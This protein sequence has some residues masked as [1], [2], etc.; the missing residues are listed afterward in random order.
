[1][2]A[3]GGWWDPVCYQWDVYAVSTE[4]P[5]NEV[6]E[7]FCACA[8]EMK[9]FFEQWIASEKGLLSR[10][11]SSERGYQMAVMRNQ[12]ELNAYLDGFESRLSQSVDEVEISP[13]S[14]GLPRM[15]MMP[16]KA[17]NPEWKKAVL[18]FTDKKENNREGRVEWLYEL[19]NCPTDDLRGCCFPQ[20]CFVSG[21]RTFRLHYERIPAGTTIVYADEIMRESGATEADFEK[22]ACSLEVIRVSVPRYLF[23]AMNRP[24]PFQKAW[25]ERLKRLCGKLETCVGL[26][27]MD[28]YSMG[29]SQSLLTG[30]GN[31]RLAFRTYLPDIGWGMG[32]TKHQLEKMGGLDTLQKASIFDAIEPLKNGGV[33]LQLTPDISVVPK[34]AAKALWKQ[35]SPYL[36]MEDALNS[37][38]DVPPSMRFGVDRSDLC[39]DEW[40]D[41]HFRQRCAE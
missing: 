27:K 16:A 1:M 24:F 33:Y 14:P 30:N 8:D 34:N 15:L 20:R 39:I 9:L 22:G 40:G 2:S 17:L 37:S 11:H 10:I 7:A 6:R 4:G 13:V 19:L 32:L 23:A 5:S 36:K 41:Y 26:M 3:S 35:V 12:S 28:C 21:N 31:F 38:R 25:K 18:H 29:R